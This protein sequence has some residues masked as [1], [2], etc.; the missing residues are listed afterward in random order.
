V[1]GSLRR[2]LRWRRRRVSRPSQQQ[3]L[4]LILALRKLQQGQ[5]ALLQR[6]DAVRA[7]P[8]TLASLRSGVGGLHD[9]LR[10]ARE[11][12]SGLELGLSEGLRRTG[13]VEA[14]PARPP[15]P[16]PELQ[17]Q[18]SRLAD[19]VGRLEDLPATPAPLEPGAQLEPL[20]A[21]LQDLVERLEHNEGLQPEATL[22][23]APASSPERRSELPEELDRLAAELAAERENALRVS[24]ELAELRERLRSSELARAELE[25]RHMG[26]MTQLA[27]HAQSQVRRL[28]DELLKKRRGLA[29]LT[30][31]NIQL[32]NALAELRQQSQAGG[33]A[34][35]A[36]PEPPAAAEAPA[37]TRTHS[38]RVKQ[39]SKKT[40]RTGTVLSDLMKTDG[41]PRGGPRRCREEE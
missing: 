33:P 17:G 24:A 16:D 22:T 32:Q 19:I 6:F 21:R 36:G 1:L 35:A 8:G 27:D 14:V 18:L 4:E 13:P 25:A 2:L 26:E 30:E 29:A 28:E 15:G 9:Q 40:R 38:R 39:G 5:L 31:E 7:L 11:A 20:Y 41:K 3:W 34:P 12:L 23:L 10:G 37:E